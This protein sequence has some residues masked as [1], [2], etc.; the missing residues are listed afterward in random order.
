MDAP[1]KKFISP[2]GW[3]SMNYPASWDEFEDEEDTCLFYNATHWTGNFRI[4]AFRLSEA[5]ERPMT[6]TVTDISDDSGVYTVYEYEFVRDDLL[7]VCTFTTF[8]DAPATVAETIIA[9]I[10]PRKAGVKYPAEIIFPRL[11]EISDID[12]GYETITHTVKKLFSKD[13]QG[14]EEDIPL[15]QRLLDEG[16]VGIDKKAMCLDLGIALCVIIVNEYDG[17]VWKS[18]I[19]G[20]REAP[21]LQR[22]TDG[23]VA[24]PMSLVWSKIKRGQT[25]DLAETYRQLTEE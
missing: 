1:I 8:K 4:S 9:S 11:S 15:L 16:H 13:F 24:D 7:F 21:V 22:E 14:S 2:M 3:Y 23:R 25:V 5:V 20:N 19:D 17:W 6:R 18:L 12:T 10:A